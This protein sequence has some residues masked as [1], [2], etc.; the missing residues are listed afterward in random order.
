[1]ECKYCGKTGFINEK[2]LATH[3]RFSKECYEQW[4][5]EQ[6]L[7][8]SQK[9]KVRCEICGECLRNI[10][11]TH[12]KKHGITQKEY[13]Q[14]FPN[15]PIFSEGLLETQKEKREAS[16]IERYG[17]DN[18]IHAVNE[19]SFIRKYGQEEGIKL[20]NEHRKRRKNQGSL[21][22][23]CKKYG[24]EEGT[25]IYNER[26]NSIKGRYTLQYFCDKFGDE[27]GQQ[28]YRD[29]CKTQSECR[30]IEK[31]IEKYG[32]EEGTKIYY[33]INNKKKI[34]L[35]NFIRKY[36]EK[37]GLV[38]FQNFIDNKKDNYKQSD[39]ALEFF[40]ILSNHFSDRKIYY[41][42][43]PQEFGVLI[44]QDGSYY[45]LDFYCLDNNKVIE[46]YGN[47]WHANPLIYKDNAFIFYPNNKAII[48]KDVW[49]KDEKRIEKIKNQMNCDILII[50][51]KD[52]VENR[53]ETIQKAINF[54]Q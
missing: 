22:F 53:D 34:S 54:L 33:E 27:E 41:Y 39:I 15:S 12:L 8:D 35:E 21:E 2:G 40:E 19:N 49:E 42:N 13:K 29:F 44:Q 18:S 10:S 31:Y 28:K 36:G 11:N 5:K 6:E 4:K 30:K 17:E 38:R 45:K 3:R 23:Y 46:F 52:F 43:H 37:E 9:T 1:M 14:Q 25:K 51:E 47:Y 50:W 20:W 24:Q 32:L 7:L 16:I 26:C 48:A